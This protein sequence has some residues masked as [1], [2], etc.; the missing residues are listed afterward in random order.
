MQ[1]APRDQALLG[2]LDST[3]LTAAL[4]VKASV[5]FG[6]EPFR[7]ERRA[8]ERL[9]ALAR[10]RLVKDFPLAVVGGGLANY[11]KLTTEGYRVIRG[12]E[13]VLPHRSYFGELTPSRL[14]HTLDL[15]EAIVH[16]QVCAHT[17]R[18]RVTQFHRENELLLETGTHR[19]APDYH[20][21]LSVAGRMFNVL[22]E[23][24]RSTETLDGYAATSIRTKLLAYEAYQDHV[25]GLWQRGNCLGDRPAFRVVFL[26]RS[27]ER[28][29]HILA[30][31]RE[32]ARNPDRRLCY[33]AT[34]DGFLA[35]ADGLR[36][37]IFL[38]HHGRWQ[39]LANPF[40]ASVFQRAPVRIAPFVQPALL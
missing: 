40:P 16:L 15:A 4:V 31:A 36:Q 3:P 12:A 35:E 20:W 37:P 39:A 22:L 18:I 10:M 33:A 29:L 27:A 38:D 25:L 34:L 19:V 24:D 9:Q 6:G 2:L 5:S 1:L 30:L 26:T 7:D 21:Q 28:A 32:C 23:L 17:H 14:A 11:Y 8:R 13:A